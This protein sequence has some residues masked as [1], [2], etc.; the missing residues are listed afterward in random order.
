MNDT[1]TTEAPLDPDMSAQELRLHM[2]ELSSQEMRVARAAIRWANSRHA[3]ATASPHHAHDCNACTFL[4]RHGKYDLYYCRK[5]GV[6]PDVMATVIA[7]Y[8]SDGPDYQSGMAFG[9]QPEFAHLP[10]AEARKRAEARGLDCQRERWV[11]EGQGE[12]TR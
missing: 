2:G 11:S 12:A 3:S 7:R 10:L 6:E 5:Q 9:F 4:G 8:G 1:T